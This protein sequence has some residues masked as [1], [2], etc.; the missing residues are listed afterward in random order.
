MKRLLIAVGALAVLVAAGASA[1]QGV[2]EERPTAVSATLLG[3]AFFGSVNVERYFTN[4]LGV[5][6]GIGGFPSIADVDGFLAV[7]VLLQAQLGR[8]E[9]S[10]YLA[11]GLEWLVSRA[12]L[13]P[14][15][16]KSSWLAVAQIGYQWQGR[17]GI[18]LRPALALLVPLDGKSVAPTAGLTIGYAF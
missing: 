16:V 6:A 10:L 14:R 3:P 17:G 12:S 7:P 13:A 18:F 1:Q 9:H 2:R 15:G 5:S 4:W 8:D 11:G